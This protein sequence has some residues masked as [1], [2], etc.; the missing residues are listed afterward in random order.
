ML[1]RSATATDGLGLSSSRTY[2]V[3]VAS[4]LPTVSTAS[5]AGGTTGTAYSATL[6]GTGGV[7]PYTWSVVSGSCTVSGATLTPG[8]AGSSCVVRATKGSD[9]NYYSKDSADTS[10]S[11]G[12]AAQATLTVT[13]TSATYGQSLALTATGGSGLGGLEI[14]RAHV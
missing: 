8:D 11:I 10:V 7:T 4:A 6:A 5:L 2:T 12:K 9:A 3:N 13:S 14:G 1:F